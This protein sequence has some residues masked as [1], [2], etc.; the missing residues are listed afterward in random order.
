MDRQGCEGHADQRHG[1]ARQ[2]E[3]MIA[4]IE[5]SLNR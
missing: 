4:E 5:D 3:R 1:E 2:P